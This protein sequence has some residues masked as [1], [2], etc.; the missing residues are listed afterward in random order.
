MTSVR[1][2]LQHPHS[3]G[4][5]SGVLTFVETTE[6]ILRESFGHE[7]RVL[8]TKQACRK[9]RADA[10]QWA[11]VVQMNSNHLGLLAQARLRRKPVILGLHYLTYQTVHEEYVPMPLSRRLIVEGRFLWRKYGR[12]NPPVFF[13]ASGRLVLRV[14]TMLLATRVIACT[15]FLAESTGLRRATHVYPPAR[16][17]EPANVS[18]PSD[19]YFVFAGRLTHDK[20]VDLLIDAAAILQTKKRFKVLII[21]DGDAAEVLRQ[22]TSDGDVMNVEFLGKKSAEDVV[23]YMAGARAN[24]VPSRWQE[25][26]GYTPIEASMVCTPTIASQCGGLPE[27]AGPMALYFARGSV[28]GLV[29]QMQ[30]ALTHADEMS[31]RGL[32]AKEYVKETFDRR[33][34]MAGFLDSLASG[35]C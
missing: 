32:A 15:A 12:R 24:V 27:T 23:G 11:D 5:I 28:P 1:V 17:T 26:A 18:L 16:T 20:G 13:E 29:N 30:H 6:E 7:V 2:L 4:V 33:T 21:G 34:S 25:P 8:S 9:E 14:A 19:P 22:R 31:E 35:R 10:V 3:P